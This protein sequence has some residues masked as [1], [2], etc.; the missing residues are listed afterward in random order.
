[1]LAKVKLIAVASI[2]ISASS[3][4]VNKQQVDKDIIKSDQVA[5]VELVQT[6]EGELLSGIAPRGRR[7]DGPTYRF[8]NETKQLTLLRKESFS[9]DTVKAF[10]G[11]VRVLKGAAGSGLSMRLNAIGRFPYSSGNLTISRV[12]GKAVDIIFDSKEFQITKGGVW[13]A[14]KS[15]ID[16]IKEETPTI[17]KYTTTYSIHYHGLIDKKGVVQ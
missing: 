16:T 12:T 14:I 13:E 8:D 2:L 4:R 17:I 11:Y 7:V 10:L 15:T 5:F 6:Q 3:C 9:I 1:M